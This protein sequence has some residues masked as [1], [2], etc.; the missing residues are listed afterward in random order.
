MNFT[1]QEENKSDY[2]EERMC[3]IKDLFNNDFVLEAINLVKETGMIILILEND[4]FNNKIKFKSPQ[5]YSCLEETFFK[6]DPYVQQI[7]EDDIIT[8]KCLDCHKKIT[9][10]K[11]DRSYNGIDTWFISEKSI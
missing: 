4:I 5:N 1:I 10:M 9:S 6:E 2:L 3:K 8:E 11:E 7:I